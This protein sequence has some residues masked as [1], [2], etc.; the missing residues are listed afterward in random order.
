MCNECSISVLAVSG[1]IYLCY[2]H[3]VLLKK[4]YCCFCITTKPS[5]DIQP[6]LVLLQPLRFFNSEVY[7]INSLDNLVQDQSVISLPV[8]S[9]NNE[10]NNNISNDD[11]KSPDYELFEYPMLPG[12]EPNELPSYIPDLLRS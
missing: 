10:T 12:E 6:G 11:E 3:N 2:T 7:P 4:G 9:A 5:S 1:F 8:Y